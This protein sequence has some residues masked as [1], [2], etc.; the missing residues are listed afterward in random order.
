M[1]GEVLTIDEIKARYAP[2]WVLIGDPQT[3]EIAQAPGGQGPLPRPGSRRG[4]PQDEGV[5]ARPVR[6]RIPGDLP[7]GSGARL[8]SVTFNPKHGPIM[9][10]AEV[11][12]PARSTPVQLVL[13]TGATTTVLTEAILLGLGYDLA[14]VTDRARLTTGTMVSIVPRVILTRL[15][16][17]GQHRFGFPVLAHPLPTAGSVHG[18]LGLDFLR[19]QVLTIDFRGGADQPRVSG[20]RWAVRSSRCAARRRGGV[21]GGPWPGSGRRSSRGC[22]AAC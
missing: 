16:A 22:R 3:D 14:T 7:R 20:S 12:G 17:L 4:L 10:R 5:S 6:P 18:L 15:S 8:M 1:D 21:A 9:V 19:D 2:D 11:T 13:D